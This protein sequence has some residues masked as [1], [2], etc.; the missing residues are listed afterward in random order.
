M[1]YAVVAV[2]A[3]QDAG[4]PALLLSQRRVH[5]RRSDVISHSDDARM[6]SCSRTH[7]AAIFII[8]G[9]NPAPCMAPVYTS[10]PALRR[11]PQELGPDLPAT[12]LAG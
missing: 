7:S 2:M 6:P 1:R 5:P 3:A 10:D 9:L 11:R 8:S 12:A 4:I